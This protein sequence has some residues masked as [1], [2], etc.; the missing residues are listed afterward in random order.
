MVLSR[1]W[2]P[3]VVDTPSNVAPGVC[4]AKMMAIASSCPGSQSSHIDTPILFFFS[5]VEAVM[6]RLKGK[7]PSK[8]NN[9]FV[10][11]FRCCYETS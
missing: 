3:H 1:V 10:A 4:A 6:V 9:A 5:P 2:L 7:A 8:E 11:T